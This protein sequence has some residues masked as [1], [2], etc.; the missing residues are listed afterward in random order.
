MAGFDIR[1][2]VVLVGTPANN[3]LIA[4]LSKHHFLPYAWQAGAFPGAGRGYLAWQYDGIGVG[5]ESVTVIGDDAEGLAEAVGTL[6]EVIAG[7][8][9]LTPWELPRHN[10]VQAATTA[11]L[12]SEGRV[13]WQA[14]LDDRVVAL[15]AEADG[16][17]A[18]THDGSLATLA[19]DGRIAAKKV[20]PT[21]AEVAREIL[22]ARPALD[23]AAKTALAVPGHIVNF[24]RQADNGHRAVA[25]W[26]GLVRIYGTDDQVTM[27]RQFPTDIGDL[28]WLGDSL[29]VGLADG[30]VVALSEE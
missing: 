3:P 9:P 12:V 2:A 4:F 28:V 7:L 16:L 6:Y 11:D 26:G 13:L 15:R 23:A 30:R 17:T 14:V 20:D 19:A 25:Y 1:G 24:A 27:A 8:E 29:V 22:A 18:A 10:Q 21:T 5:Q